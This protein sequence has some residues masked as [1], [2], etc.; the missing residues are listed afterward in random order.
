MCTG[1]PA[2][3]G[4]PEVFRAAVQV[5]HEAVVDAEES[6]VAP[7]AARLQ[8]AED[9]DGAP[10]PVHDRKCR[11]LRAPQPAVGCQRI[12]CKQVKNP[13][14]C[15]CI[16]LHSMCCNSNKMHRC[17][18]RYLRCVRESGQLRVSALAC[19]GVGFYVW[20]HA[21]GAHHCVD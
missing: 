13:S 7:P 8:H 12:A 6:V 2:Q 15:S 20:S 18:G 19:P 11:R 14:V 5:G 4:A 21:Q 3:R 1:L 9:V 16:N 10:A 17:H